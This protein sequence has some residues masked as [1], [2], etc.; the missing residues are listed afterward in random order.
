[1]V[2]GEDG[3][4]SR[5][6]LMM[7]AVAKEYSGD[8]KRAMALARDAAER[9]LAELLNK[10]PSPNAVDDAILAGSAAIFALRRGEGAIARR[11]A[12]V[13]D[14]H[15]VVSAHP[16]VRET[17]ASLRAEMAI[18]AGSPS[19][20]MALVQPFATPDSRYETRA[21]LLRAAIA[22]GDDRTALAQAAWLQRR[23]GLAYLQLGCA[24]CT[25]GNNVLTST[26]AILDE[27]ELLAGSQRSRAAR[28]LERFDSIWSTDRLPA[29]VA[30]RRKRVEEALSTH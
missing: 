29:E 27:A 1:M 26:L 24:H 18:E 5:S 16:S 11:V 3:Y 17:R 25:Q 14:A 8:R 30:A 6:F 9:A 22:A 2:S 13:L 21:T 23:R 28:A 7:A 15:P 4:D 12:D 20:A 10:E 19:R